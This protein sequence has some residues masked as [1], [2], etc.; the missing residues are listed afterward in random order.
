MQI[1]NF[2]YRRK[3]ERG[4]KVKGEEGNG[5][6]GGGGGRGGV[7][8]WGVGGVGVFQQLVV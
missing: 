7:G 8:G 3:E 6:G 1:H 2:F 4:G 5:G